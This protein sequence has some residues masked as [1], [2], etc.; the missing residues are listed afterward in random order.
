MTVYTVGDRVRR[1]NWDHTRVNDLAGTITNTR[2]DPEGPF[3]DVLWDN[4][5]PPEVWN[6]HDE[7]E[8][9][10]GVRPTPPPPLR[11]RYTP[12]PAIK[13]SQELGCYPE[14]DVHGRL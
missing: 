9:I 11:D 1:W 12:P 2:P 8:P 7:L 4:G 10:D 6:H 13:S 3:Y 5:G 14:S